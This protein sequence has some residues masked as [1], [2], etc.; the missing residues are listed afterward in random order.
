M[1]GYDNLVSALETR[2]DFHSA[3]TIANEAI[4]SAGLE[5]RKDL[6]NDD[7]TKVIDQIAAS[8]KDM[9]AIKERLGLVEPT[10][11]ASPEPKQDKQDKPP[12]HSWA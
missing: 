4:A 10:Q 7:L 11:E 8:G 3:R 2:F 9:T 1:P 6:S 5:D 12:E